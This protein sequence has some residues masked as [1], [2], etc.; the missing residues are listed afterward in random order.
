MQESDNLEFLRTLAT[1]FFKRT[2]RVKVSA[3]NPAVP[4]RGKG[5]ENTGGRK[6]SVQDKKEEALN[7]PLVREAINIFG[8]KVIEIKHL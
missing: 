7:H 2:I 5:G 6:N 8:G 4:P 1:E 3:L